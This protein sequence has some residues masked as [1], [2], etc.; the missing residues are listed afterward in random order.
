ME[1]GTSS[2][3]DVPSVSGAE[4]AGASLLVV[5]NKKMIG[6]YMTSI[7]FASDTANFVVA[8]VGIRSP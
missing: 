5:I 7:R 1:F 3:E 6:R 8:V 4:S 2:I